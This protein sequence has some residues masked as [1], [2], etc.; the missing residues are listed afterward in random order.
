M[1]IKKLRNKDLQKEEKN[2]SAL[3]VYWVVTIKLD[4]QVVSSLRE[5]KGIEKQI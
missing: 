2:L 5:H 1:A 3:V 4:I